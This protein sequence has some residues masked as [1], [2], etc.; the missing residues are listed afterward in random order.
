MLN[1]GIVFVP[2]IVESLGGWSEEAISTIS[3]IGHLQGQR[4][5][6]N[7]PGTSGHA[8]GGACG[9]AGS[10]SAQPQLMASCN[11]VLCYYCGGH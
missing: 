11:F 2:L 4:L 6:L 1:L 9:F 10:P 3:S 5:G 7:A 8:L